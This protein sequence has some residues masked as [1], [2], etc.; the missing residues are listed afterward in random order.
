MVLTLAEQFDA[1]K[2]LVVSL[3]CRTSWLCPLRSPGERPAFGR[4]RYLILEI[5]QGLHLLR[6][7]GLRCHIPWIIAGTRSQVAVEDGCSTSRSFLL[8]ALLARWVLDWGSEIST[9]P[10]AFKSLRHVQPGAG[11][12]GSH[13][14]RLQLQQGGLAYLARKAAPAG[15]H[16]CY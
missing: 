2:T 10:A 8:L 9:W 1:K 15:H 7:F 3:H 16:H 12:H 14:P 5:L 6:G 4:A 11:D 13:S